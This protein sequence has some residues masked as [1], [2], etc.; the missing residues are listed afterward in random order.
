MLASCVILATALGPA[1][2]QPCAPCDK[3][4]ATGLVGGPVDGC[5]LT[6]QG[7]LL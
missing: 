2:L 6:R 4:G 3:E 7:T 5:G 1:P